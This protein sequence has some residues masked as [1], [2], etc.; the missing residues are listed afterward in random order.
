MKSENFIESIAL[1]APAEGT[2]LSGNRYTSG[3]AL[4]IPV[5]RLQF[6]TDRLMIT[7]SLMVFQPDENNNILWSGNNKLL[8]V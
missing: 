4:K 2:P 3:C 1:F 6:G 7:Q 8:K 5:H